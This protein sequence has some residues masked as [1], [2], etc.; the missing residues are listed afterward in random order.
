MAQ[1]NNKSAPQKVIN[2]A[3]KCKF[4]EKHEFSSFARKHL[5]ILR[6]V[7]NILR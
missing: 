3:K 4:M 2:M 7:R 6:E 5:N 1:K